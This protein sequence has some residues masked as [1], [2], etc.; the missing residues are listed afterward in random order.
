MKPAPQC[1]ESAMGL[2]LR[3]AFGRDLTPISSRPSAKQTWAASVRPRVRLALLQEGRKE[4]NALE[5]AKRLRQTLSAVF[6]FAVANG[7][8]TRDPAAPLA[9]AMKSAPRQQHHARRW[10]NSGTSSRRWTHIAEARQ[11]LEEC[12]PLPIHSCGPPNCALPHGI[13]STATLGR[14]RPRI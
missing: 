13:R 7:W 1:E 5:M 9:G 6:R 4:R 12:G 11:L 8:A 3:R 2:G 10:S 14:S